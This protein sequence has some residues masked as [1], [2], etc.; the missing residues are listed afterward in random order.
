MLP[1][2][3]TICSSREDMLSCSSLLLSSSLVIS[4]SMSSTLNVVVENS[5]S[6][7]SLA[8]SSSLY[9]ESNDTLP[10]S[11]RLFCFNSSRVVLLEIIRFLLS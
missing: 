7:F 3:P 5:S 9:T 11:I 1:S 10:S 2:R 6:T 4:S 8:S